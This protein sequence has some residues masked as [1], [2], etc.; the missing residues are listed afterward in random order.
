MFL[1]KA[2]GNR[3][4]TFVLKVQLTKNTKNPKPETSRNLLPV[5]T[6]SCTVRPILYPTTCISSRVAV[7][8]VSCRL[9][10]T[11]GRGRNRRRPRSNSAGSTHR[12]GSGR[13]S[14]QCFSS[15]RRRRRR[16]IAAAGAAAAAVV[17]AVLVALVVVLCQ[18]STASA[19][20]RTNA[21]TLRS[22]E[23]QVTLSRL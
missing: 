12:R 2:R 8:E 7:A 17:V 16:R 18:S 21:Q 6:K 3:E 4:G 11:A 1:L 9:L 22:K 19:S 5:V 14:K 20:L 13:G 23:Q 10:H 15:R